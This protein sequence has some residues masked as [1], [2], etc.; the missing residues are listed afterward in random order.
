MFRFLQPY[1]GSIILG[2]VVAVLAAYIGIDPIT[3]IFAAL[4]IGVAYQV[5]R[6]H[7]NIVHNQR[8]EAAVV[9][10]G[11][12]IGSCAIPLLATQ[13]FGTNA[14]VTAIACGLA[15][16]FFIFAHVR[17]QVFWSAATAR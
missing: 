13:M 17:A 1:L 14:F 12:F 3:S 16:V 7:P 15:V 2:V 5:M 11:I 8:L 6:P 9:S 4:I 10:I